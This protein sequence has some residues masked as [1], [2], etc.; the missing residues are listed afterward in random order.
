MADEVAQK[1]PE[2]KDGESPIPK[3]VGDKNNVA[4]IVYN[5]DIIITPSRPLPSYDKGEIKAYAARGSAKVP[6]RLAALICDDQLTPRISK[7]ANFA[8]IINP[9][10]VRL[11]ASGPVDWGP[12][13]RRHYAFIYEDNLGQ[14]LMTND[15]QGG[16]G[17]KPDNVLNTVVRPMLGTLLDLRNKDIVHGEIRLGNIFD[18]GVKDP[19]RVVLGECLSRPA[20]G[21]PVLYETIERGMADP[22]GRGIGSFKD[23][24][25][26]FG[27]CLAVLLR[28]ND[29]MKGMNAREIIEQKMEMG[30]Y[31]ALTG[32]DRFTGA[33][34]ELLRGLLYDDP[35]Q[36]WGLEDMQAWLDGRRLTP[37]QAAKKVK[38]NRPIHF[39]GDK[40]MRPEE[41]ARDLSLNPSETVQ[42]VDSG[43]LDQ[44]LERAVN[45][46]PLTE[47][48]E[49]ALNEAMG[50]EGRSAGYADRVTTCLAIA[51]HP[52]APIRYKSVS[53]LPDGMGKALTRAFMLKKDIQVYQEIIQHYFIMQWVDV[54]THASVDSGSL[55]SKF[56]SCRAFLRQ[57][58]IGYGIERCIYYLNPECF[59]LSE[60][61][62]RFYVRSPEDLMETFEKMSTLPDKP[63]RFFDRHIVAFLSVK[64]RKNIDPYSSEISADQ[65]YK[66]IL[67]E[68]KTLATIQKRSRLDKYPGIAKW[69]AE[70]LEP[71]YERLHDRELRVKTKAR[72][73][74]TAVDGDLIKMAGII[75]DAQLYEGDSQGFRRA[76]RYYYD[77]EEESR[78]LTIQLSRGDM[79]GRTLGRQ[80]SA[81]FSGIVAIIVILASAYMAL[82]GGSILF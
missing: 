56:D 62:E 26:S 25:Y 17:W 66:K 28:T 47:R 71:V 20:S 40:Y 44:W 51:M 65:P 60:K 59:C 54:H 1:E 27:V 7:A 13:K 79:Y 39:N 14:P 12:D 43:E 67:G 41:L 4:D 2:L 52:D 74:K 64:D 38:A 18:G 3:P 77:L 34:L 22:V 45:D 30:S 49:K 68:L 42:L 32:R 58:A 6:R 10:L 69:A 21:L 75:D 57:P 48:V 46:K 73:E 70:N 15:T 37:K 72:I 9:S 63:I 61:I 23:D 82:N 50:G 31:G 81:V 16:L 55:I 35:N 5:D 76:M 36:R 33:I 8:S 80:I 19:D 24:L 78:K 29:P 11:I 53:V